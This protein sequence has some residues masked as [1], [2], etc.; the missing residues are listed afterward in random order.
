M[1]NT[2][3][4]VDLAPWMQQAP[5]LFP[6]LLGLAIITGLLLWLL[7][8]VMAKAGCVMAGL[9]LGGLGAA[10]LAVSATGQGQAGWV[11]GVSIGGA[12]AGALLAFLLFRFWVGITT[13]IVLALAIPIVVLTWT[14]QRPDT[15]AT[16]DAAHLT[17][18]TA[19]GLVAES[20][21]MQDVAVAAT[22]EAPGFLETMR[23]AWAAQVESVNLW[24]SELESGTRSIVVGGALIGGVVGLLMGML[25]P[26][27][28]ASLQTALAG[29]VLMF[30]PTR[31]LLTQYAGIGESL[32]PNTTRGIVLTL[33]LITLVGALIQ[34]TV[35]RKQDDR[36]R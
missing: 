8:G 33:G 1:G 11:A 28:A 29:A 25:G 22:Q 15:S 7:G 35:F 5:A 4:N 34:W 2:L 14:G 31:I 17:R 10:T 24:W 6:W 3:P 12:I 13:G 20:T 16:A 36:E 27:S 18:D 23:E 30:F 19:A 9:V 26:I 21:L 32:F